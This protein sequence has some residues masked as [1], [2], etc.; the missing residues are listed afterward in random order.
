MER[1]S[2]GRILASVLTMVAA[3][4]MP[5]AVIGAGAMTTVAS[6]QV[7][8][9]Q[10]WHAVV[11]EDNAAL[12]CGSGDLM[13]PVF[14]LKRGMV[15][16]VDGE[17]QG[18]A[19]VSY[20]AGSAV[21]VPADFVRVDAAS[22]IATLTKPSRLK[23]MNLTTGLRGSWKDVLDQPLAAGT[24]VMLLDAEPMSDGR[25]N[26]AWRISP[27]ETAQAFVPL[28]VLRRATE[29][30]VQQAANAAPA[31]APTG[32]APAPQPST[33]VER[34][35]ANA[36]PGSSAGLNEPAAQPPQALP[37]SAASTAV[38]PKP[39]PRKV[40][41]P[42]SPY[43]K[44]EAAF[45]ALRNESA[46]NAEFGE[47]MAEFQK[48]IENLD[49][50]PTS[51]AMRGRLQQRI[52]YL[53]LRAD[54]QAQMRKLAAA[55]A[56]V[57]ADESLLAERLAEVERNRQYTIVGR[58]SASTIYNGERLP[59]MYRIQSVGGT[60]PRTLAYV[61]PSEAMNIGSKLG[62]IVGVLGETT[63]D[64]SLQLNIINPTRVD[65]LEAAA[66]AVVEP[67]SQ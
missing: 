11:T 44:L 43:E 20:P 58:L 19:R 45:Q 10:P 30:E 16:R 48:A 15:L 46:D 49:D 36:T 67:D 51:Q 27:P 59:L 40:I 62:Q 4:G 5:L 6:A 66:T 38:E 41:L 13:Y 3:A 47:L 56:A 37:G 60:S 2:H 57:S 29:A 55:Q 9:V 50:S 31:A 52:E 8:K 32:Q 61:K 42:P 23:A 34:W 21:F 7:L 65:A 17:G 18:W 14:T 33:T 1:R 22:R 39:M 25:G 24:R 63:V 53:K 26:A 12:R 28:S 64:P 35:P 54:L